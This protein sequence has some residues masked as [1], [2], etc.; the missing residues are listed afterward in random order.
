[1]DR[2]FQTQ[3]QVATLDQ[4]HVIWPPVMP[5]R[6]GRPDEAWLFEPFSTTLT[7]NIL[8]AITMTQ[9]QTQGRG[10]K[11]IRLWGRIKLQTP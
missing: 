10:I 5:A 2:R 3:L 1:M 7:I 11:E 9:G 8:I 4:S 6:N